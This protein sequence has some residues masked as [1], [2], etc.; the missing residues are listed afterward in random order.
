MLKFLLLLSISLSAFF[1]LKTPAYAIYDPRTLPNNHFGIHIINESD[2][3]DAASLLNSTGGDWGYVKLVIREDERDLDKWQETLNKMRRLHLIPVL[4][5]ATKPEGNNWEKPTDSDIDEWVSFLAKLN[6]VTKNRYVVIFNEPNHAKEWGGEMDPEGY[7]TY[8]KEFSKKLKAKS[9][10]FF[11]LPAGLDASAPNSSETMEEERFISRMVAKET[12]IFEHIDGWSS[13]SYPNPGF[14][15]SPLDR[16]KGTVG[17]FLWEKSLL[18]QFTQKDLPTFI[19]ETGWLQSEG[20]EFLT[21]YPT[22]DV[23]GGYYAQALETVWDNPDLV[24]IIPFL[25]NYQDVPFDHFSWKKQNSSE[26]NDVYK[27]V[28]SLPKVDGK[29]KQEDKI[30]ILSSSF[31]DEM[32]INSRYTFKIPIENSGQSIFSKDDGWNLSFSD[33][34]NFDISTKLNSIE[35]GENKNMEFSIRTPNKPGDYSSDLVVEKDGE[36]IIETPVSFKLV[37]PPS[38]SLGANF[39]IFRKANGNK[40]NFVIY[41]EDQNI[42]FNKKDVEFSNGKAKIDNIYNIVPNRTYRFV[43]TSPY[44]LP[45]QVITKI[46]KENE[47]NFPLFL[48]LDPSGDGTL[49]I[50]DLKAALQSPFRFISRILFYF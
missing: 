41:D 48:P 2:L 40:Y 44:Y 15:G 39:W 19:L 32:I 35:P 12:D 13:H 30:K 3:N 29:P 20:K 9:P 10:D 31:P 8:L 16:G 14:A 23:V 17:T 18:S 47:I 46:D 36:K 4:R 6:W 7:A 24:S 26:F 37:P 42:L 11:V 38:V 28:K 34:S 49:N 25:L 5:L 33:L 43:L 27:V 21:Y 22:P 1:I 50:N 45:R